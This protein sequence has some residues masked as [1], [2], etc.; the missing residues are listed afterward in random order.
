MALGPQPDHR[1]ASP[2][3]R[4]APVPLLH[5]QPVWRGPQAYSPPSPS[6]LPPSFAGSRPLSPGRE[7][8]AAPSLWRP[9]AEERPEREADEGS[10]ARESGGRAHRP[11]AGR[12]VRPH[13]RNWCR[14]RGAAAWEPR[15]C[16]RWS[17]RPG[18]RRHHRTSPWSSGASPQEAR[19]PS[20]SRSSASA[21]RSASASRPPSSSPLLPPGLLI[22]RG[23]RGR[24]RGKRGEAR[25]VW[26]F[27]WVRPE[28]GWE[29]G[30]D[31]RDFQYPTEHWGGAPGRAD[32]PS[33]PRSPP[34]PGPA[35]RHR[36]PI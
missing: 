27:L 20:R 15:P 16:R 34:A 2:R 24:R 10:Q 36:R 18:R 21:A 8:P 14:R 33:Y 29:P 9:G 28:E 4:K 13:W 1:P 23:G 3:P 7:S 26:L 5:H 30:G 31:A 11:G 19:G 25:A 22:A 6:S 32:L 35:T 12:W 17:K